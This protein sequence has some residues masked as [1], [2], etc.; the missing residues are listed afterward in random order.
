MQASL[1]STNGDEWIANA[2]NLMTAGDAPQ[3]A[4]QRAAGGEGEAVAGGERGAGD[5]VVF[6]SSPWLCTVSCVFFFL[7]LFF[8]ESVVPL[9]SPLSHPLPA[10]ELARL[11]CRIMGEKKQ[12]KRPTKTRRHLP[13]VYSPVH[14]RFPRSNPSS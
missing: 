3:L 10:A 12:V 11:F 6:A 4:S 14:A 13:L 1:A 8:W 9:L 7:V 5:E 2:I